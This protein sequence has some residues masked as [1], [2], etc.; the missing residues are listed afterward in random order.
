MTTITECFT[1]ENIEGFDIF[2]DMFE[3]YFGLKLPKDQ[4]DSSGE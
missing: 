1:K 3:E 4:D 2:L